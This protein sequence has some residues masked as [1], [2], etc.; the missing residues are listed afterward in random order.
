MLKFGVEFY[1]LLFTSHWIFF[2]VEKLLSLSKQRLWL[3]FD[4]FPFFHRIKTLTVKV[5]HPYRSISKG[6]FES[7]TEGGSNVS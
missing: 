5:P 1:Y 4:F 6:A 7:V 2:I 3:C